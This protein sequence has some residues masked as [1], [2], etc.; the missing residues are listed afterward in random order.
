MK[1]LLSTFGSAGDLFP[2]VPI[3][4]ELRRR[5]SE[6]HVALPRS[7][8]LYLRARG[9]TT[10]G[11]GDGKE[12]AAIEDPKA[13]SIRWDGWSAFRHIACS[14]VATTLEHDVGVLERHIESWHPDVVAAASYATAARL[15]A[16]RA[17]LPIVDL[18][19]YPQH[20]RLAG[21]RPAFAGPLVRRAQRIADR[22]EHGTAK[23]V[24]GAP[25]DVVLHD[26]ALL[27]GTAP[28]LEPVGFPTWDDV[29]AHPDDQRAVTEW[30]ARPDDRP[31]VL[32]TLGSFLGLDREHFW[33]E[34]A[35]A[36][37]DLSARVLMVGARGRWPGA[38]TVDPT[39]ALC[40]GFLPLSPHLPRVAAV[41]HHGGIGTLFSTLR[42]G[43]P[44]VVVPQSFDQAFN[45]RLLEA[46]GG[47]VDARD[48]GLS[49][50]LRRV[51]SPGASDEAAALAARLLDPGTAASAAAVRIL[52]ADGPSRHG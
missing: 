10:I 40:T 20:A 44:A 15:A 24:W 39:H 29:P 22:P 26:R 21:R 11:L 43:R 36:A 47:G 1:V 37:R 49:T 32:A 45:A 31:L 17:S 42:T 6:V 34:I 9:M 38:A 41:V 30:F 48:I 28:D 35:E 50:A 46:A 4:E 27:G 23:Q 16:T 3:A 12:V 25:A 2:I 51:L 52:Q 14:Y 5:G 18:S 19:I 8:G 33:S 13:T 7:I